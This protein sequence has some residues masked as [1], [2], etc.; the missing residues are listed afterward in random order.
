M[1][2]NF[3]PERWYDMERSALEHRRDNGR[4]TADGFA[5]ALAELQERYESM[6]DRLNSVADFPGTVVP[7]KADAHEG[8]R[9]R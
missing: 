2:Y 9:R 4:L 3:D 5:A 7:G 8:P 6:M 1:T